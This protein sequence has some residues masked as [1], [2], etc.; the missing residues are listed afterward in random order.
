MFLHSSIKNASR[1]RFLNY[2]RIKFKHVSTQTLL[3]FSFKPLLEFSFKPFFEFSFKT[4]FEFTLKTDF[5][6]I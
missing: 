6:H 2:F 3:E 5:K 4:Q 1:K